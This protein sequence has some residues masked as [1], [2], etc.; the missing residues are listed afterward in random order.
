MPSWKKVITSGSN[1]VLH[2]ITSSGDFEISGNISGSSTSTGSFGRIQAST[3][4]G[5]S[6]LTIEADNFSI[7]SVGT[8]SGSATSTGSFGKLLGDGSSLTGIDTDLS[9]D[10]TPQLGGN[11]DLNSNNITG[12]GNIDILGTITAQNFIVSSS[13]T[14]IE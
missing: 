4:G 1:A 10:T 6:P 14:S 7:D 3:I 9:G 8:I 12:T 5:N 2:N 13:V 11:L